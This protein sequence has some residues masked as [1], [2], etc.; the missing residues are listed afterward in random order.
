MA[1]I[2]YVNDP[3]QFDV[4]LQQV[5]KEQEFVIVYVTGGDDPATGKSWCGDCVRAKPNI[6]QY[7][8]Q[9]TTGKLLYC[10]VEKRESWKP[11]HFY[12]VHPVLK[13]KG[14]PTIVL[15]KDGE[16]VARAENDDDFF[17]LELLNMIAKH[18]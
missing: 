9:N 12:K 1:D 18:E 10:I 11:G 6:E 4:T 14:V 3:E 16:V 15:L 2:V 17:N 13:V 5:Q 7:V 8:L